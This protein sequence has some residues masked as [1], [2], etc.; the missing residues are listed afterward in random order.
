MI[1]K[2]DRMHIVLNGA[3][4][5]KIDQRLKLVFGIQTYSPTIKV[6]KNLVFLV[7]KHILQR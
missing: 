5:E 7:F 4:F 3:P 1:V 2:H 6:D